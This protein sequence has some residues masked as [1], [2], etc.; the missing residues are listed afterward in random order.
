MKKNNDEILSQVVGLN[1]EGIHNDYIR[2]ILSL[3]F[4]GGTMLLFKSCALVY[5]GGIINHKIIYASEYTGEM[6]FI[7][8]FR[9]RKQQTEDYF[10]VLIKVEENK[11]PKKQMRISCREIELKKQY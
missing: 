3:L 2:G 1:V 10:F 7:L 5:D 4:E 9:S 6:G 11:F 8:D